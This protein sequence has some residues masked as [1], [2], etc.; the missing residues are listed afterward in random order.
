MKTTMTPTHDVIIATAKQAVMK[1][2]IFDAAAKA[3]Y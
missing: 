1:Q 3:T 2:L